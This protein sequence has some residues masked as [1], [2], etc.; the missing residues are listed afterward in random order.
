MV[1]KEKQLGIF[2]GVEWWREHWT[3]MP[4]FVQKKQEPYSKIIIRC[5]TK[6]DLE[7]L[8]SVLGQKLTKQTK[9]IWHPK[10]IRGVGLDVEYSDES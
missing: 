8:S 5:E 2:G 3:G 10:F 1:M 6:E 9:S 7:D 4:E